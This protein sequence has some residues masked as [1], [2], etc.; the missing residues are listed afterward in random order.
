MFDLL[1]LFLPS[2]HLVCFSLMLD[3]EGESSTAMAIV[4]STTQELGNGE[5]E[6][7]PP[8]PTLTQVGACTNIV[9]DVDEENVGKK[10]PLEPAESATNTQK[11]SKV[12]I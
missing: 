1:L 3:M 5:S 8:T 10:R 12:C 9:Q 11:R 4:P 7:P 2:D 6:M